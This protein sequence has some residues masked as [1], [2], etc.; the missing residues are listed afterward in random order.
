MHAH[1]S[2]QDLRLAELLAALSL[3]TD[4]GNGFVPETALRSCLLAVQLGQEL[5]LCD[6]EG[7]PIPWTPER[8]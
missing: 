6:P 1:A 2:T 5:G 4:L 8:R 3:A 7:P